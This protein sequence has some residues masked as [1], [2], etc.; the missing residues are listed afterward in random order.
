MGKGEGIEGARE[1]GHFAAAVHLKRTV[2]NAVRSDEPV[3]IRQAGRPV[4][5]RQT[6]AGILIQLEIH[7]PV[8]GVEDIQLFVPGQDL[9]AEHGLPQHQKGLLVH[10][11]PVVRHA[12]HQDPEEPLP[13][14]SS[15]LF[16]LF[17][18]SAVLRIVFEEGPHRVQRHHGHLSGGICQH[19]PEGADQLIQ[20]LRREP[21][22]H[23]AE[24]SGNGTG[25]IRLSRVQSPEHFHGDLVPLVHPEE[26]HDLEQGFSC[27]VPGQH[28]L[29]HFDHVGEMGGDL[30]DMAAAAVEHLVRQEADVHRLLHPGRSCLQVVQEDI[31]QDIPVIQK[32]LLYRRVQAEIRKDPVFQEGIE[33][34]VIRRDGGNGAADLAPG[35]QLLML[36]AALQDIARDLPDGPP[37]SGLYFFVRTFGAVQREAAHRVHIFL[38]HPLQLEDL[39]AVHHDE[40]LLD[41]LF[42]R[43]PVP[44]HEGAHEHRIVRR[45]HVF[46]ERQHDVLQLGTDA[47]LLDVDQTVIRADD[48]LEVML[49]QV[50]HLLLGDILHSLRAALSV[51]R[52]EPGK[53][54]AKKQRGVDADLTLL[55]HEK[56][57]QEAERLLLLGVVRIGEI[58]AQDIDIGTDILPVLLAARCLQQVSETPLRGHL[59]HDVDIVLD[60]HKC[61]GPHD[62]FWSPESGHG[63]HFRCRRISVQLHIH[64]VAAHVSLEIRQLGV[65][66]TVAGDFVLIHVEELVEDDIKSILQ[67]GD[68]RDL[69]AVRSAAR[70]HAEI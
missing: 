49:P 42:P 38:F 66:K 58:L 15:D 30:H 44:L 41:L 11:L 65:D 9:G 43:I 24:P 31:R 23:P 22:R 4:V 25:I 29:A 68:M 12:A 48:D 26:R 8:H 34:G 60:S 69:H 32:L 39:D 50:Q 56:F 54:L 13:A 46:L 17:E 45:L 57:V 35:L 64:P 14:V 61:Q 36:H 28:V 51:P 16:L 67:S 19:P 63:K 10:C 33:G 47:P 70:F 52:V 21:Q 40:L 1:E 55:V 20:L 6:A 5:M 7:F 53:Q 2:Q 18:T 37:G 62:L 27:A 3:Q 59:V